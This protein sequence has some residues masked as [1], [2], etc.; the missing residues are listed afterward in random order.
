[1]TSHPRVLVYGLANI[2]VI[3][4]RIAAELR[5]GDVVGLSGELGAGK[6]SLARAILSHLGLTGEAPSPSFAIVQ[7][8]APPETRFPVLHIDL[9]RI[10]RAAEIAELGLDEARSDH[11][12][13]IEWPERIG[14]TDIEPMLVLAIDFVGEHRRR[15]TVTV[16][17]AWTGRWAKLLHSL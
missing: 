4:A 6:T 7:P 13:L 9:Y 1:M 8:Y 17:Q 3:A 16:P 14:D 5:P 10:E 2:D 11:A 12:F 15:L